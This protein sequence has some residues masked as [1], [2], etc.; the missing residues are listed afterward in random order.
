MGELGKCAHP[1]GRG[2][3]KGQF[4]LA[5]RGSA[6]KPSATSNSGSLAHKCRPFA[7]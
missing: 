6:G 1:G 2:L 4:S 7:A 3:K 5:V